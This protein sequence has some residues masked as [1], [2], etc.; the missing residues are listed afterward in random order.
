MKNMKIPIVMTIVGNDKNYSV[1]PL[2]VE[3]SLREIFNLI[4]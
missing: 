3:K 1:V 2:K 4:F